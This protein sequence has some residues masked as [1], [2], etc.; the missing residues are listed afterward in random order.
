MAVNIVA[1]AREEVRHP[2]ASMTK[3]YRWPVF[4]IS[5]YEAEQAG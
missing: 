1:L 3:F 5:T 4:G 2:A